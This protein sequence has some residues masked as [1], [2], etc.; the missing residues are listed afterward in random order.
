MSFFPIEAYKVLHQLFGVVEIAGEEKAKYTEQ[1][2]ERLTRQFVDAVYKKLPEG[3]RE[4]TIKM[5]N[6]AKTDEEKQALQT[7]FEKWLTKE[8]IKTLFQKVADEEFNDLL[9]FVY[10]NVA[11]TEQKQKL[12]EVFKPELLKG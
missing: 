10:K 7:Q 1:F 9:R 6:E 2:E 5:A 12:E 8:E 11:T 3:E 4:K